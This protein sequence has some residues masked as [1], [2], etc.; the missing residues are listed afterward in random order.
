MACNWYKK[1]EGMSEDRDVYPQPL[2]TQRKE[3]INQRE[4]G[5]GWEKDRLSSLANLTGGKGVP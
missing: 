5:N 1:E 2:V 4:R 3:K